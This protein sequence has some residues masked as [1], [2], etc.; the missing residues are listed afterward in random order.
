MMNRFCHLLSNY[1]IYIFCSTLK[2]L[3]INF[4]MFILF[5]AFRINPPIN[6]RKLHPLVELFPL[7]H[8]HLT[9]WTMNL[10]NTSTNCDHHTRVTTMCTLH[11]DT[12]NYA[13]LN[14]KPMVCLSM[15][16][17]FTDLRDNLKIRVFDSKR[18][19]Y[20]VFHV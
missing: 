17:T 15:C 16:P 3:A 18:S 12:D 1:Q 10:T 9:Y 8:R 13:I 6:S 7:T 14:L 11:T 20:S 2:Y 4:I 5:M 19:C